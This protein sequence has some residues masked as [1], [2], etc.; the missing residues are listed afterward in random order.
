MANDFEDLPVGAFEDGSTING[1]NLRRGLMGQLGPGASALSVRGGIRFAPGN[2]CNVSAPGG[3]VARV[4]PGI[5]YVPTTDTGAYVL[6]VDTSRDLVVTTANATNPR[7]DTVGLEMVPG[8]PD[9][10]RVRMLDGTPAPAPIAP[11]YGVAGGSFLPLA[12]VRV[13]ANATAPTS[14]TDRRAWIAPPG[15][16]VPVPGAYTTPANAT[17]LAVGT[18]IWDSTAGEWLVKKTTSTTP[19][20]GVQRMRPAAPGIAVE[21]TDNAGAHF[22]NGPT[23]GTVPSDPSR[24]RWIAGQG[25]VTTNATGGHIAIVTGFTECILFA[26]CDSVDWNTGNVVFVHDTTYFTSGPSLAIF[27]CRSRTTFAAQASTAQR[28]NFAVFGC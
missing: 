3:M 18:P 26:H 17:D 23:S 15:S 27:Q 12:D 8:T 2:P 21:M 6:T 1:D 24:L 10:W 28:V 20:V 13:N 9:L 7:I 11:T 25:V 5:G 19:G 16:F 14:V 4:A 22:A